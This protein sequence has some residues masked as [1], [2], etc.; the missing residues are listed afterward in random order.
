MLNIN[1]SVISLTRGDSAYI[2]LSAIDKG[3]NAYALQEGDKVRVQVRYAPNSGVLLF[4]G[5][6][7][8]DVGST[9]FMWHIY[10]EDTKEAN[11]KQKYYWDAQIE[12]A[13]GDVMTFIESSLFKLRDEVSER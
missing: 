11:V 5:D 7:T 1:G 2:T 10:P 3:G 12:F 13:N 4:D 9:E 8:Y 6:V